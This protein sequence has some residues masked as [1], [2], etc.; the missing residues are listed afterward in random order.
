MRRNCGQQ[1]SS[2]HRHP[3]RLDH[4]ILEE[5]AELTSIEYRVLSSAFAGEE[6]DL[7]LDMVKTIVAE[8]PIIG[9]PAIAMLLGERQ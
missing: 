7:A 8:N 5:I 1:K 3:V 4:A 2:A 6:K 9:A